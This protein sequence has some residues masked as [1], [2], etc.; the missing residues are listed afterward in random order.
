M[1][2]VWSR[3]AT[4]PAAEQ[5]R[6]RQHEGA[7]LRWRVRYTEDDPAHPWALT[8]YRYVEEV[9][10]MTPTPR[11]QPGATR[12]AL[13]AASEHARGGQPITARTLQERIGLSPAVAAERLRGMERA[14]LLAV[15]NDVTPDLEYTITSLGQSVLDA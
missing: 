9:P 11:L 1:A 14:G 6:R 12:D 13:A 15:A 3:H 4:L 10:P 5:A 2:S 7:A 8:L